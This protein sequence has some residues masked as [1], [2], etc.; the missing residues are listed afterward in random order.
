[1]D[2]EAFPQ[3]NL[4]KTEGPRRKRDPCVL[5]RS[6]GQCFIDTPVSGLLAAVDALRVHPQQ[7]LDSVTCPVGCLTLAG[8]L[9]RD[10]IV[11]LPVKEAR[12]IQRVDQ[13]CPKMSRFLRDNI[14]AS[15]T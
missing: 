13:D 11:Q 4:G 9:P 1:M 15:L 10:I 12:R 6:G 8:Y 3:V 2:L 14:N 5:D 7:H